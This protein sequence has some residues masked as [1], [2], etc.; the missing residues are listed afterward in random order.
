[1]TV[2]YFLLYS[3]TLKSELHESNHEV[4]ELK[5]SALPFS[6]QEFTVLFFKID[7]SKVHS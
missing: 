4:K 3:S 6:S 2:V 1:M 7:F 5:M